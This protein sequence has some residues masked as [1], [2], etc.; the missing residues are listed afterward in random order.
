MLFI[1]DE[2]MAF[3]MHHGESPVNAM[4]NDILIRPYHTCCVRLPMLQF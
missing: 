1:T 4:H 2:C 3:A